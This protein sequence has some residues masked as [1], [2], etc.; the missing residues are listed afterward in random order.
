MSIFEFLLGVLGWGLLGL[1]YYYDVIRPRYPRA[2][3]NNL[4]HDYLR[5]TRNEITYNY[6]INHYYQQCLVHDT[7]ESRELFELKNELLSILP[8]EQFIRSTLSTDAITYQRFLNA[9]MTYDPSQLNEEN[10]KVIPIQ[11]TQGRGKEIMDSMIMNNYCKAETLEWN[12]EHSSFLMALF[13]DAIAEELQLGR[14]RR[15]P[16]KELWGNHNYSD[17]LT[18]A[19]DSKESDLLIEKVKEIIP[20]YKRK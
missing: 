16:F 5:V 9:W 20:S 18:K 19:Q 15:K 10:L 11:F 4:H 2:F 13:A 6:F 17:L 8:C 7:K 1:V 12:N 14:E 3:F